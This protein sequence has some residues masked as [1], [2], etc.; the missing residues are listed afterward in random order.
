MLSEVDLPK[1]S[2]VFLLYWCLVQYHAQIV[3]YDLYS[4]SVQVLLIWK[5]YLGCISMRNT[6]KNVQSIDL[7][8]NEPI[9]L[10]CT[11]WL[12][13]T[14]LLAVESTCWHSAI[15]PLLFG[16]VLSGLMLSI[17]VCGFHQG[18]TN[19]LYALVLFGKDFVHI[20][21]QKSH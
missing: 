19:Q 2:S 8:E 6:S 15:F 20:E 7:L 10:K 13:V 5:N 18:C 9:L 1:W 17:I 21:W 4:R 16:T 3:W 12:F 14:K 11:S